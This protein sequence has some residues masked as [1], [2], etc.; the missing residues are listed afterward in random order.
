[1][2]DTDTREVLVRRTLLYVIDVPKSQ[3]REEAI[4]E[5]KMI[6]TSKAQEERFELGGIESQ[7]DI[8]DETAAN[9]SVERIEDASVLQKCDDVVFVDSNHDGRVM[10]V[11]SRSVKVLDLETMEPISFVRRTGKV[12]GEDDGDHISDVLMRVVS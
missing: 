11:T 7:R 12:W 10:E 3:N 8:E 9:S 6:S 2:S 4:V 1:M 5:A